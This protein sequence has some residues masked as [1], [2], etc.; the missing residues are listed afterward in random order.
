MRARPNS[1]WRYVGYQVDRVEHGNTLSE[2]SFLGRTWLVD[3]HLRRI[4]GYSELPGNRRVWRAYPTEEAFQEALKRVGAEILEARRR[5][6]QRQ[7]TVDVSRGM[8]QLGR[9][10]RPSRVCHLRAPRLSR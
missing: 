1:Q 2:V 4:S 6:E 10:I 7:R 3:Y 5:A 8:S 9:P